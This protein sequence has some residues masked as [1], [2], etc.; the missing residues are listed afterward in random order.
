MVVKDLTGS[1][2]VST[3]TLSPHPTT[4][5]EFGPT[6]GVS[7]NDCVR[8]TLDIASSH[9]V[10]DADAEWLANAAATNIAS[11][12]TQAYTDAYGKRDEA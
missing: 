9:G 3:R 11:A 1:G 2:Y 6:P 5:Q 7:D 4:Q 8:V 10:V 12:V